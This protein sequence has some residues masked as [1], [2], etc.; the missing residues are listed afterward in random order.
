M[1]GASPQYTNRIK[2]FTSDGFVIGSNND[3]NAA[4]KTYIW[5][6]FDASSVLEVGTYIGDGTDN[7]PIAGVG[8]NPD[9]VWI[10]PRTDNRASWRSKT[11]PSTNCSAFGSDFGIAKTL[12]SLNPN[13]F[14]IGNSARANKPLE[15]YHYVAFKMDPSQ[16]F[17]GSYV[18]N[19]VIGHNIGILGFD[20]QYMFIK[21]S[22]SNAAVQ[23]SDKLPLCLG[24]VPSGSIE[25]AGSG[26]DCN[27]ILSMGSGG[28]TLG[29]PLMVNRANTVYHYAAFKACVSAPAARPALPAAVSTEEQFSI[30]PNPAGDFFTLQ[31]SSS[32]AEKAQYV[33]S[34]FAG[35]AVNTSA[36]SLIPGT[37][38]YRVNVA[39]LPAGPYLLR[40][41]DESGKSKT[42]RVVIGR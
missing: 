27:R 29:S 12:T 26:L 37:N 10:L 40:Y 2:S 41:T 11:F 42:Q 31:I 13:G 20:I 3:V 6:A 24:A 1:V 33:L 28:F 9:M 7:R 16:L 25:F 4:G 34:D 23:K 35:K 17:L 8:F 19:G 38:R 15:V 18:G 32:K 39:E 5:T 21:S 14:T 30:F 36:L 22:G